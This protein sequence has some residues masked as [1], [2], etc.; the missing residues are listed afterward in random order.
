[1]KFRS[2]VFKIVLTCPGNGATSRVKLLDLAFSLEGKKMMPESNLSY[3]GVDRNSPIFK[4]DAFS[5]LDESND[6]V[7]YAADRFVQHL[8]DVALKTVEKLIGD[9]IV[10]ENP[11]I[12]DLM[13][14]W[15]S[16]IPQ[17]IKAAQIVGLG[18][19]ENEL[20]KN[21]A[22]FAYITHDLNRDPVLP[23]PDRTLDAVINT[24]SVD[25]MTQPI[26]VFAEVG[27]ILKPGGL[28]LVIFSNRMFPEKAV[29]VWREASEEERVI[30]V[31][32]FFNATD[33]FHPPRDFVSLGK[34]R[35]RDDKYAHL[36]LPSDPIY[37][38][39]AET[40]GE[41]PHRKQRPDIKYDAT[42]TTDKEELE[43]RKA[44][45]KKTLRCPYCGEKLRKWKVPD[46]PFCQTWDN[47]HMYICFN[48]ACPYFARGWDY[49]TSE[50]NRGTS[51]RFMYNPDRDCCM[52]IP[53][54]SHHALKD[55]IVE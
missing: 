41:A 47:D 19:N 25:Y 30:L 26:R 20:K 18:L 50:G 53:V 9:L 43:R 17:D 34:I 40:K 33:L 46:N 2:D 22:L 42:K 13:A 27:R 24:V 49:M 54:P 15:D 38:V 3:K 1:M 21:S 39:Y 51:Y 28:F 10:E 23:F 52:P 48:D 35:P 45:V 8:D 36:G 5:R 12:L 6:K 11:V 37:A 16:H 29:K 31:H 4:E 32:E 7:F 14:G 55:G 44:E